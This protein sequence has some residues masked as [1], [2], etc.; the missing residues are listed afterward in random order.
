MASIGLLHLLNKDVAAWVQ[1][2]LDNLRVDPD[3]HLAKICLKGAESLT[4]LKLVSYSAIAFF[5]GCL[6][7]TEG[8]GLY[9]RKRWAEYLVVIITSTLL[10]LEVY[11][12]WKS[13][14]WPKVLLIIGNLAIIA[15]L[16]HLILSKRKETGKV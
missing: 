11:E 10:P 15:Y 2:V 13:I 14:T 3:N 5:Y 9:L 12:L 6:F 4:N 8:V 16:I 1:Q 7:A